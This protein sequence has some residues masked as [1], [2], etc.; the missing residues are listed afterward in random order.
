MRSRISRLLAAGC[1]VIAGIAPARATEYAF[2]TYALGSM[3]FGAGMTP[4]A[5]IYVT[6]VSSYYTA[7]ISGQLDFG[8][9]VLNG[10]AKVK[11]F[12]SA[13]NALYVPDWDVLGGHLGLAVTVPVGFLDVEATIAGEQRSL[14]RETEGWGFGD[15]TPRLQ[16]GWQ[17]GEFS[18]LVYV[19]TVAPTGRYQRGFV[20]I[21]GLNR[22]SIDTGWA[23]TWSDT[24]SKLQVNGTVGVTFNFENDVT[25]YE[26]GD[27]FH[28]EWAVGYELIKGLVIGVVGYDYRQLT[29]DSGAGARLGSFKGRV[30]A[31]GPGLSYTTAIGQTPV[32]LSLR[33]Y[34]EYNA[35]RRWEGN[36]TIASGT[37]RF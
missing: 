23:F 29:G 17:H 21:I 27:E 11:A 1:F 26:S 5:G 15:V 36:S 24:A 18:H 10:G 16:L 31:I 25:N 28:A 12:A 32:T 30:D 7:E 34:E 14:Q 37:I 6:A 33:H 22:P 19:Q 4:P 13:L 2:S 20:P 9:V 3:A 8:G 35:E